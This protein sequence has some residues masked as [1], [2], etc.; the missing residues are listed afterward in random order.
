MKTNSQ[1]GRKEVISLVLSSL[2]DIL[3]QREITYKGNTNEDTYLIGG[4]SLVDSLGLVTLVTDLEQKL[5]DEYGFA[6]TLADDRAMSQR[7]SPFRT[8]G[9]LAD[10]ILQLIAEG[11]QDD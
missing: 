1:L 11:K 8:V 4:N 2:K 6:L 10:Y 5:N 7:N 9:S 3:I